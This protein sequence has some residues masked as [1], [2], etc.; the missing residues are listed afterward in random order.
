M[1]WGV[2][3]QPIRTEFPMSSAPKRRRFLPIA[4][5]A[6]ALAALV[7]V[8]GVNG[9]LS[10]WTQAVIQNTNNT[11]RTATAVVLQETG[12][13]GTCYSN[14]SDTNTST[15]ATINKYGG[16]ATPLTPGASTTVDVVFTNLGT[17]AASSFV[18]QRQGCTQPPPAAAG[19]PTIRDLCTSGDL[20]V[21][22]SCSNG[23]TYSAATAWTDLVYAGGA[24]SNIPAT[25][26]HTASLAVNATWTCRFTVALASGANPSAS[27]IT[28]SQALTWTLNA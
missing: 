1:P 22:V 21:A 15:C 16:T 24:P 27:A 19:P 4:W 2:F 8:L 18:L 6:S 28:V 26:T 12:P 5:A 9:T 3:R 10:S 14:T 25:L 7:L 11:V 13:G 17:V 23:G 20:T